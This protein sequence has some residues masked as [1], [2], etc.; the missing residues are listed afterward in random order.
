MRYIEVDLAKPDFESIKAA[1]EL[2]AD[3]YTIVFPS[4][5][6]PVRLGRFDEGPISGE[7]NL[8]IIVSEDCDTSRLNQYQIPIHLPAHTPNRAFHTLVQ[9]CD[10]PLRAEPL[11]GDEQALEYGF[12]DLVR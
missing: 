9:L 3:G 2:L 12:R 11:R 4:D 6:G 7:I 10:F 1:S 5:T 8:R